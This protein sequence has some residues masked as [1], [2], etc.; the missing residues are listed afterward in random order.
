MVLLALFLTAVNDSLPARGVAAGTAATSITFKDLTG[1]ESVIDQ[2]GNPTTTSMPE[3]DLQG[4]YIEQD[5]ADSVVKATIDLAGATTGYPA[6]MRVALGNTKSTGVCTVF[7]GQTDN[8]LNSGPVGDPI[9]GSLQMV[10]PLGTSVLADPQYT[11]GGSQIQ[12]GVTASEEGDTVTMT[13]DTSPSFAGPGWDCALVEIEVEVRGT[14]YVVDSVQGFIPGVA[15]PPVLATNAVPAPVAGATAK[16][17]DAD[18][19]GVPDGSDACPQVPGAAVNGCM[20]TPL[21]RSVVLGTKRVVFDRLLPLTGAKCPA[22][23]RATAVLKGKTLGT[24]VIGTLQHGKFCEVTG[25]LK[26]K[27]K[28]SKTRVTIVGNGV[29]K[30]AITVSR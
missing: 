28:V 15:G 12:G 6:T 20:S 10:A 5:Q 24:G 16:V 1:D 14:A 17:L 23:V 19:D 13:T 18:N 9:D 4:G 8:P 27:K 29:A 3:L 7:Q 11:I 26:L 30:F 21:A 2:N 22:G 25:V